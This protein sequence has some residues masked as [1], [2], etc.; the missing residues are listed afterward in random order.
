MERSLALEE[1]AETL[2]N[3]GRLA[4]AKGDAVTARACFV[5][6]VWLFPRLAA[7][8]PS[9]GEPDAVVAETARLESALP[10]GGVPPPLPARFRSR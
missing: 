3:L 10:S 6:A 2:L 5:R 1:R 9:A 7:A 4:L 8:I